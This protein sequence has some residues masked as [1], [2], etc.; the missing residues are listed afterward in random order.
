MCRIWRESRYYYD[1]ATARYVSA[2][3][4]GLLGGVNQ[5]RYVLAPTSWV[6]PLGLSEDPCC[7]CGGNAIIRHYD[8]N[9]ATGH[10]TVE[11]ESGYMSV[12]THQ[13]TDKDAG[14]TTIVNEKRSRY[15]TGAP[16]LHTAEVPLRD[17]KAAMAYQQSQ[18]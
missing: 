14:T 5:Y 12:H 11:V 9:S 15:M 4:I 7:A 10:Y 13:V 16:I 3:P 2:D 17:A 1:A 8:T 6:D 18:I